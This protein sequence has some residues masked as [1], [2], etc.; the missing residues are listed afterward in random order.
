MAGGKGSRMGKNQEKLLLQYKKPIIF[1]VLDALVY[2]GCFSTIFVVTSPNSPQTSRLVTEKNYPTIQTLGN[3]YAE[4]LNVALQS[5]SGPVLVTPADLPLLDEAIV[6]QLVRHYTPTVLWRSVLVTSQ[7]LDSLNLSSEFG[8]VYEGMR[9][10]YTGI[11]LVDSSRIDKLG[12]V[13]ESYIVVDDKR[14]AFNLNT[15]QDYELLGA[16]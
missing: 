6:R 11:S 16:S 13:D 7:F 4:D 1:H 5:V 12:R 14:I 10:Y 8:V 9:H 15:S 3:N 2:S